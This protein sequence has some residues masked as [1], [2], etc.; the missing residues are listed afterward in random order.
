MKRL[1][2]VVFLLA[3]CG[4]AP[5]TSS[6]AD[7]SAS[8]A[9]SI[10]GTPAHNLLGLTEDAFPE[11]ASIWPSLSEHAATEVVETLLIGESATHCVRVTVSGDLAS[12]AFG[13][14]SRGADGAELV[15]EGEPRRCAGEDG[16]ELVMRLE[17]DSDI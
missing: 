8:A 2:A 15:C 9:E 6:S 4:G 10:P 5:H 14:W 1:A 7:P 11:L 12:A 3:A 17:N 13:A 16:T